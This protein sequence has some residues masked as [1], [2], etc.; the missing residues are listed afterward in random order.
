M[1]AEES[2]RGLAHILTTPL[3]TLGTQGVS[4]WW[5]GEVVLLC[6][7]VMLSAKATK[8]IVGQWVLTRFGIGEG[9]REV[10]STLIGLTV[11]ALGGGLLLQL[12]GL[13][14]DSLALVL[15]GL[16]V[17]VGFGLQDLTKNL[18]SG[19]TLLVERK[20]KVGDLVEFNGK[21]GFIHEIAIRSTVVRT[22]KGSDVIVPN[23]ELTNAQIE[24][25]TYSDRRGRIDITVHVAPAIDPIKVTEVLLD[26]AYAEESVL[27]DPAPRVLLNSLREA[28]F[29]YEL[30]VWV[31]GIDRAAEI[32]SS[33]CFI[34]DHHFRQ[35]GITNQ[36]AE[37]RSGPAATV[38]LSS[39]VVSS[40]EVSLR[41]RLTQLPY[42][43]SF[44][45]IQLRQLI[46]LG[47]KLRLA[48][49][50]ILVTQGVPDHAFCIVLCGAIDAILE[51]RKAS[52]RGIFRRTATAVEHSLSDHDAC[53]HR[54]GTFRDWKGR[55]SVADAALSS[56]AG[57]SGT[58]TLQAKG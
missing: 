46:Q 8:Q 6:A 48:H 54:H 33:L 49:G 28:G 45:P 38:P 1:S 18:A 10:L 56:A 50:E 42:F 57:R 25:W 32:R 26:C 23:A 5:L 2:L 29:N 43:Q 44:D 58:R 7:A 47:R 11:G 31:N 3:F 35:N 24:N 52:R 51:T 37:T 14:L 36:P 15:G 9:N 55:I 12:M 53:G 19:I 17:G 40:K 22:L 4:L 39:D 27:T 21:M 30:H 13:N 20:L 16:G 41:T 34:I